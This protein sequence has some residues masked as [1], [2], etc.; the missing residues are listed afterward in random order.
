VMA[1]VSENY[2]ELLVGI[3]AREADTLHAQVDRHLHLSFRA[4]G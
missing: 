3:G 4:R 2:L 1:R